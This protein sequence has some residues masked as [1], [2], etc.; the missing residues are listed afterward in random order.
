MAIQQ[1]EDI[2]KIPN[3]KS[4]YIVNN[5]ADILAEKLESSFSKDVANQLAMNIVKIFAIGHYGKK[6]RDSHE[7]ELL[8]HNGRIL[9][10]DCKHFIL[11][12][13]CDNNAPI[14]M[15]RMTLGVQIK[16]I[17][18]DKKFMKQFESEVIDKK[19]LLRRDKLNDEE[20]NLMEKI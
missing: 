8:Y 3:V 9:A 2:F 11:I 15:L 4:A 16:S 20:I 19:I 5:R 10:I 18:D 13:I 7:I 12:V 6:K 1:L 17:Q 14:S